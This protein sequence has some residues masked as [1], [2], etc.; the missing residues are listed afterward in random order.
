MRLSPW[1]RWPRWGNKT[2]LK[3]SHAA[4]VANLIEGKPD[5][6]HVFALPPFLP[7]VLLHETDQEAAVWFAGGVR[8]LQHK[9]E[10]RVEP[11]GR[12][13][14]ESTMSDCSS[15]CLQH[16]A[17]IGLKKRW[18]SILSYKGLHRVKHMSR[19][20]FDCYGDPDFFSLTYR[21]VMQASI[22]LSTKDI[23][24]SCD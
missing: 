10:L 21:A 9:L 7:A 5:G 4:F 12:W 6:L 3:V 17:L 15:L 23:L 16:L 1:W 2:W 18:L 24:D 22:N 19:G 20:H 11:K 13:E 14:K 8:V